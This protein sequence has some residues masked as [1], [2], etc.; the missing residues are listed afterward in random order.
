MKKEAEANAEEDN[1]KKEKV[2]KINQADGLIFQTE[3][4]I[5]E[6]GDK[7]DDTDKSRLENNIK[8]L[9]EVMESEDVEGIEDLTEK[10][11]STWQ[12]IST[13]LYEETEPTEPTEQT[14][15]TKTDEATD[16]EFEEV[17]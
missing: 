10:L 15:E 16:V 14:E 12:E 6:F 7:L 13:K 9:K 2:E 1:K 8:E 17:K 11:N 4:Q 3:K 5:K